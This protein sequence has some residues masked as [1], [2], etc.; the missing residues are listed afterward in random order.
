MTYSF[1]PSPQTGRQLAKRL[2]RVHVKPYRSLFALACL[3][4]IIAAAATAAL[5]YLLQPV[6]DRVFTAVDNRLLF[7]FCGAVFLSFFVKGVASYGESVVMTYVGQKIISDI[8]K[9][10]FTHL[11]QADLAFFHRVTSGELLSRFTNDVNIMRSA[12]A[13]VIIGLGKDSFTLIFLIGVMFYRDFSLAL[14][15][16]V[17]FPTA[18]IPIAKIGRK[19]RK[20][21]DRTQIELGSFTMQLTQLFQ[22]MRVVKAY[23]M[24]ETESGRA[25]TAI[26]KI[27]KLIYKTARVRSASHPVVET[28][29]G[30]AII[31]VI[32]YGGWQVMHHNRTTGEFISFI[33]A[34]LLIYEPLKRLSNLNSNLQEGL[35][36]AARVFD[37]IDTPST[38]TDPLNPEPLD[39]AKGRVVFDKVCFGYTPFKK[40]LDGLS[41]TVEPGK[42]IAFV[43]A[44]GAGKSTIINLIPRFYDITSGQIL[45]DGHDVRSVTLR[46]LRRQIALVSQEIAL[47][48]LTI[49][50][51]IA[52]GN[53]NASLD[54]IHQAAKAAAAAEF[55]EKLPDR[56]NTF[57]GENGVR[58]SGGQRQRIAIARA[59]LKDAP[60]LLLDEAT[61]AL[62]TDSERQVQN[63]LKTLMKGRTTLIVAHRLST[64]VDADYIYVLDDGRIKEQGNHSELLDLGGIYARLWQAQSLV[65]TGRI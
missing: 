13:N 15:A 40:A 39:R 11:M 30:L 12:I 10:V 21:T 16:F 48:D 20:V 26:D 27:F 31:V 61:S 5:P 7:I 34:M 41:F 54:D 35:A 37:I 42:T 57:V 17:I 22:G 8:Q 64:V 1:S 62:D 14:A 2:L 60:I 56:Y 47:F 58:L 63:A 44:S 33:G 50:D 3:F 24:E 46:D 55:I 51:N 45:I 52:Y 23:G 59:M 38:I 25:A 18:V 43:G 32:A 9:R 19:M 28:L 36:G 29:G 4:M 6:F 53:P 49:A 65:I